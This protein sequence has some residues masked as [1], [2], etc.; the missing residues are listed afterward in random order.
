M[1]EEQ[2]ENWK[3]WLTQYKTVL[4]SEGQSSEQRIQ[5]QNSAN[6][7]YIPRNHLLQK[8][9][10]K[11]EKRDFSEVQPDWILVFCDA[12]MHVAFMAY[13]LQAVALSGLQA[14][15]IRH[16]TSRLHSNKKTSF[17]LSN[18]CSNA[19]LQVCT[20]QILRARPHVE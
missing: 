8:A 7:C 3:E 20:P 5:Q 12:F 10:E 19:P 6:P 1:P 2:Q 11:A 17:N 15:C 9:I 13:A 4:K 14:T 16:Q 18:C